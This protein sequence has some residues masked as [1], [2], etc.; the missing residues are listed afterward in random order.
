MPALNVRELPAGT[1]DRLITERKLRKLAKL[2]H[3][4]QLTAAEKALAGFLP[5][6]HRE[7]CETRDGLHL[8][9]S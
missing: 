2:G 6:A 5:E 3:A 7:G 4:D 1:P 8:P 9:G